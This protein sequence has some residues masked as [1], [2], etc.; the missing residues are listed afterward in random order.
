MS[1]KSKYLELLKSAC[2][3]NNLYHHDYKNCWN[4][5]CEKCQYAV[6]NGFVYSCSDCYEPI[7][8]SRESVFNVDTLP[9]CIICYNNN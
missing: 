4:D 2:V 3:V 7:V 8:P 1:R 9:I 6:D 5:D